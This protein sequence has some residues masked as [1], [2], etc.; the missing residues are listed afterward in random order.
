MLYK[1]VFLSLFCSVFLACLGAALLAGTLYDVIIHQSR[2]ASA[3]SSLMVDGVVDGTQAPP[4]VDGRASEGTPLL[5]GQSK[6]TGTK[7]CK[8]LI[9][10]PE[11]LVIKTQKR[12]L[13]SG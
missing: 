12:K 11:Q 3:S 13:L 5:G 4:G 2:I 8:I 10:N 6:K 9:T 7:I 1:N